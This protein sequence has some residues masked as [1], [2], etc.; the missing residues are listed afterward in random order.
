MCSLRFHKWE[1]SGHCKVARTTKKAGSF[2]EAARQG[3]EVPRRRQGLFKLFGHYGKRE[4]GFGQGLDDGGLGVFGSG[5]AGSSHLADEEVLRA[6]QHFLF[7]EGK[8][9]AA[10]EGNE[11]LEDD[12]DFEE[13]PGAHSLRILFEAVFPVVVRV[14]FAG[15]KKTQDFAVFRGP[16]D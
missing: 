8:R 1:C 16:N 11:T 5:V 7:A 12:G 10:A 4:L 9:L 13:G 14:E 15:F 6:F 3:K 2:E